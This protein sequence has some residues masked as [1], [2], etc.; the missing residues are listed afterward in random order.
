ETWDD[1][2]H[3][4]YWEKWRG[5]EQEA[6]EKMVDQFNRSQ[7]RIFVHY[8]PTS[9]IDQKSLLAIVGGNPPDIIGIWGLNVPQFAD[10]GAL[11]GLD[12][13]RRRDGLTDEHYLPHYLKICQRNGKTVAVPNTPASIGLFYNREHFRRHADELR[14]A[15]LD[16]NRPPQTIEELDKYAEIL[17]EYGPDG[18]PEVYGFLPTEPGYFSMIW[19]YHFGGQLVDPNSG[20]M[21]TDSPENVDAYAWVKSYAETY[22]RDQVLKFRSGFGTSDSPQNAFISGKV[23][24]IMQGVWFP[25][26]VVRHRPH[27]DYGAAP[28]PSAEG[29]P[30]PRGFIQCDVLAIPRGAPHPEEAWE[31]LH[32]VQ[33]E[34]LATVCRLQGKHLP[35]REVPE[36]FYDGHP[37]PFV[38]TFAELARSPHSFRMPQNLIW[39]QYQKEMA[40]AFDHIWRW[41]PPR[42]ELEGLTGEKRRDKLRE[43][44]REQVRRTLADIRVRM[45]RRLDEQR[46]RRARRSDQ[47]A[48]Q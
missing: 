44:C 41:Q 7:D 10:A 25:S 24:M 40:D 3:L 45:Q 16:P 14:A 39:M 18:K 17:T 8:I 13:F 22:G 30:G 35:I 9:R 47:E 32:W 5:W 38:K 4:T 36:N 15:G 20:E 43:L 42:D 31:F 48:A 33:T 6:A 26:F 2:V 37:N 12:E 27:M 28:F 11:M 21:T 46:Q 1:R 29:V 34:G 19:G 23:S